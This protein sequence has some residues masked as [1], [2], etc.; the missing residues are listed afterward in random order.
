MLKVSGCNHNYLSVS[1]IRFVHEGV[2]WICALTL[3]LESKL[4]I[5]AIVFM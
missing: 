4:S 2:M 5:K 3:L 1:G